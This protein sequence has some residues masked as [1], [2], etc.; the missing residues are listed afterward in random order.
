MNG[1]YGVFI[2]S[3]PNRSR[4][5]YTERKRIRRGQK[6]NEKLMNLSSDSDDELYDYHKGAVIFN[7][8]MESASDITSDSDFCQ[9]ISVARGANC[10]WINEPTMR[11]FRSR[12]S[13]VPCGIGA[14]AR[15]RHGSSP[16]VMRVDHSSSYD[17]ETTNDEDDD[18]EFRNKR[19]RSPP[20]SLLRGL[21]MIEELSPINDSSTDIPKVPSLQLSK[22][23]HPLATSTTTS[24]GLPKTNPHHLKSIATSTPTLSSISSGGRHPSS[25]LSNYNNMIYDTLERPASFFEE[26]T[27]RNDKSRPQSE[28]IS[29][30]G[31]S[32]INWKPDHFGLPAPFARRIGCKGKLQLTMSISGCYLTVSVVRAVYFLDPALT[33]ASSYI[34]VE[35]KHN[36][37]YIKRIR[38]SSEDRYGYVGREKSF[39]TRLIPLNNRPQFYENFTFELRRHHYRHHD[40]LSASVWITNA[41]N[42]A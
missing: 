31:L 3:C 1:T 18:W 9:P 41:D 27:P 36:P 6:R 15:T 30:V 17:T 37:M 24:I 11:R 22:N 42:S 21:S 32:N 39:R 2:N 12:K 14:R 13:Q 8:V 26:Q 23:W 19:H 34:R 4:N 40:L 35:I 20:P 16:V 38:S 10:S 25:I 28:I 7:I 5:H 33:Q 29:N